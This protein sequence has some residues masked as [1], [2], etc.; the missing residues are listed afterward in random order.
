MSDELLTIDI[1]FR[2]ETYTK[3][4]KDKKI[5]KDYNILKDGLF[6]NYNFDKDINNEVKCDDIRNSN[7]YNNS[8]GDKTTLEN[9]YGNIYLPFTSNYI[10]LENL[11][12]VINSENKEKELTEEDINKLYNEHTNDAMFNKIIEPET[13]KVVSSSMMREQPDDLELFYKKVKEKSFTFSD[14]FNIINDSTNL[15]SFQKML[16]AQTFYK[17]NKA[18]IENFNKQNKSVLNKLT[19]EKSLF[20][21]FKDNNYENFF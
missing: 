14:Y 10:T 21:Q 5:P 11:K 6:K 16:Y 7:F 8:K 1:T 13:I 15:N 19:N 4:S 12:L 20:G 9:S 18:I 17:V 2:Y 3:D